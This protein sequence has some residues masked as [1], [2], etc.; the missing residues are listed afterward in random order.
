[1]QKEMLGVRLPTDLAELVHARARELEVGESAVI[2]L[3]VREFFKKPAPRRARA[4]A[5]VR[6]HL[7][8]SEV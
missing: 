1:M 8:T 6:A 4:R 3:A 7:V 2:R 5:R